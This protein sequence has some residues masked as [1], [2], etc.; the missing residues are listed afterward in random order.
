M[1]VFLWLWKRK[2]PLHLSGKVMMLFYWQCGSFS[3]SLRRKRHKAKMFIANSTVQTESPLSQPAE[4]LHAGGIS[5]P[6]STELE[7]VNTLKVLTHLNKI[8]GSLLV[9]RS[10]Q[11]LE[12]WLGTLAGGILF[13][14]SHFWIQFRVIFSRCLYSEELQAVFRW[15]CLKAV[16]AEGGLDVMTAST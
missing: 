7:S 13:T 14:C 8:L 5:L 16:Y 4:N 12:G 9:H 15:F 3:L 6:V 1:Q 10:A 11:T 2:F